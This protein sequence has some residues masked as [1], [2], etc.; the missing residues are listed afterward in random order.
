MKMMMIKKYY[1][2]WS[3]LLYFIF[4]RARIFHIMLGQLFYH[5]NILNPLVPFCDCNYFR[6][7]LTFLFHFDDIQLISQL[8]FY[9]LY[10]VD[11]CIYS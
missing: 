10:Y 3:R 9:K 1:F 5:Y 2:Q 6:F 7:L 4:W 8:M 11:Q